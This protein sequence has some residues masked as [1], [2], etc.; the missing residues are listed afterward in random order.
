MKTSWLL[1]LPWPAARQGWRSRCSKHGKV[2][3]TVAVTRVLAAS[4][5][6]AIG[7][8]RPCGQYHLNCF[9]SV[10]HKGSTSLKGQAFILLE[11]LL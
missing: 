11:T 9:S 5:R 3:G 10:D 4:L 8:I 2:Y 7:F 6:D 1:N